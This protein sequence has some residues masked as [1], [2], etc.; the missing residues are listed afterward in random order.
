MGNRLTGPR[1]GRSGFGGALEVR[2]LV[3]A[4]QSLE[5]LVEQILPLEESLKNVQI[6]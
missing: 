2:Y 1:A 6:P 3:I 5:E 4:D